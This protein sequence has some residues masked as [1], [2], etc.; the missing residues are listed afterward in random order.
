MPPRDVP[1]AVVLDPRGESAT[2]LERGDEVGGASRRRP[3][4]PPPGRLRCRLGGAP[5]ARVH[6]R[7][8][9]LVADADVDEERGE[10]SADAPRGA[11]NRPKRLRGALGVE[12]RLPRAQG[13]GAPGGR[14][15][16]RRAQGVGRTRS[17]SASGLAHVRGRRERLRAAGGGGEGGTGREGAAGSGPPTAPAPAAGGGCRRRRGGGGEHGARPAARAVPDRAPR[18][19]TETSETSETSERARRRVSRG[20][21]RAREER[22]EGAETSANSRRLARA[23]DPTCSGSPNKISAR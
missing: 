19:R 10:G 16:G 7:P 4:P 1:F 8:R 13:A 12:G 6:A 20:R 2:R 18:A 21:D 9:R 17:S 22:R 23:I 15:R 5:R 3:A 14:A 11:R